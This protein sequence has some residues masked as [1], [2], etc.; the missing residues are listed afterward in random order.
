MRPLGGLFLSATTLFWP[1][2]VQAQVPGIP[3]PGGPAQPAPEPVAETAA[4]P[5]APRDPF[6]PV[7]YVPRPV[8]IS[9]PAAQAGGRPSETA[10]MEAPLHPQWD[11]AKKRLDIRGVSMIGRDKDS[12]RPRYVAMV[13]GKLVEEGD[14]VSINFEGQIYRWKVTGISPSGIGL[15]KL[16]R[17]RE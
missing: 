1:L 5:G 14:K 7:G 8:R 15:Q 6:W 11:E 2:W 9:S 13:A 10:G 3:V 4:E 17:R 12:N 16:D